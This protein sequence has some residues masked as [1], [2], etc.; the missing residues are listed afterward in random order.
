MDLL[1]LETL[2]NCLRCNRKLLNIR[3]CSAKRQQEVARLRQYLRSNVCKA[4][5]HNNERLSRSHSPTSS[6][7]GCS[8]ALAEICGHRKK[9]TIRRFPQDTV[10]RPDNQ[11]KCSHD[12]LWPGNWIESRRAGT[13][14]R[15][16]PSHTHRFRTHHVRKTR[17]TEECRNC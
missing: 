14:A 2:K 8:F 10:I 9:R 4:E 1:G 11:R 13:K 6:R 17:L 15:Q 3:R 7:T 12:R 5:E 16:K